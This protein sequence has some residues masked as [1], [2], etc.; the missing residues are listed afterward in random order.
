MAF[1]FKQRNYATT[2]HY[3][4]MLLENG[5]Q[6]AQAKKAQQVVQACQTRMILTS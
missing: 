3:A 5:P 6:E 4:R 1:C 2:A